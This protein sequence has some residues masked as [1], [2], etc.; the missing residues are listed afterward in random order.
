MS[1]Y[2]FIYL[3]GQPCSP[4]T[5]YTIGF[6]KQ[7]PWQNCMISQARMKRCKNNASTSPDHFVFQR[8]YTWFQFEVSRNQWGLPL[9]PQSPAHS[10][11]IM[12]AASTSWWSFPEVQVWTQRGG[13]TA[14][15][16]IGYKSCWKKHS[17]CASLLDPQWARSGFQL[18]S[19]EN[20][21]HCATIRFQQQFTWSDSMVCKQI[22]STVLIRKIKLM[23]T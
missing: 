14:V 2:K 12:A 7:E 4:W 10:P 21:D 11:C 16:V 22:S 9:L 3:H 18:L 23:Q 1:S 5:I 17:L 13:V 20:W 8:S 19:V 6:F 15:E